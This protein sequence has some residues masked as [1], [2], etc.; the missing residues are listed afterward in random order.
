MKVYFTNGTVVAIPAPRE[1][2]LEVD[3][4]EKEQTFNIIQ[5]IADDKDGYYTRISGSLINLLFID[6][7]NEQQ[8]WKLLPLNVN[9]PDFGCISVANSFGETRENH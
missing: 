2:L 3:F 9:T 1:D 5:R 8:C 6:Y 7:G 4:C